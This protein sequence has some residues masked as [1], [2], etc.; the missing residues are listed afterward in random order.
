LTFFT[1]PCAIL[2]QDAVSSWLFAQAVHAKMTFCQI[3]FAVVNERKRP[4]LDAFQS[5][6]TQSPDESSDRS[7]RTLV[8]TYQA[9]MQRC[10]A[11]EPAERPSFT[12]ILTELSAMKG[13]ARKQS[14]GKDSAHGSLSSV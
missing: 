14:A 2:P 4:V 3:F 7:D 1:D 6:V 8:E 5:A 12:A 13:I 10:W 11:D 9:L